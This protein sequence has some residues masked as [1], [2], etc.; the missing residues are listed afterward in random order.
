[1]MNIEV[2]YIGENVYEKVSN[3]KSGI[4]NANRLILY[5]VRIFFTSRYYSG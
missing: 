5:S 4:V 1:M 2:W 3:S